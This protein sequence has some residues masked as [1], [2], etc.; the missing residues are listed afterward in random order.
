MK[1]WFVFLI[2]G[3]VAAM[4]GGADQRSARD[5]PVVN[6][7]GAAHYSA[8]TQINRKNV[9]RLERVWQFDSNDQFEGSEMECNPLI[10][11]GV[12]Y[13]TTPRLR[14]IALD[15]ATGKLVWDFDA[16][17]GQ[18][19]RE[20]QRNR[21]VAYWADGDDRRIFVGIDSYIYAL[22]A[23]TGVPVPSFGEIGRAHV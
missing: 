9:A 2:C 1:R 15:A 17:R 11:D 16:H 4:A 10:V 22:N 14:V 23:K 12:L 6:G 21:G 19:V 7:T 8:L 13:A 3:T 18:R 5:W 20:K